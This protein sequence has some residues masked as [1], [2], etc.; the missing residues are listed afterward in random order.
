MVIVSWTPNEE[1]LE[2]ESRLEYEWSRRGIPGP[3]YPRCPT[4]G[5]LTLGAAVRL[6]PEVT[7]DPP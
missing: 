3:R 6:R 4:L 2:W 5:H 7:G 1:P